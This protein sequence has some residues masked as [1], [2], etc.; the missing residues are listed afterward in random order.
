MSI[1][2]AHNKATKN[3]VPE[4]HGNGLR[5]VWIVLLLPDFYPFTAS[6]ATRTITVQKCLYLRHRTRELPTQSDGDIASTCGFWI[7]IKFGNILPS[8]FM[9]CAYQAYILLYVYH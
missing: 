4:L 3:T 7:V 6:D 8:C 2:T 9:Y 1:F 5:P